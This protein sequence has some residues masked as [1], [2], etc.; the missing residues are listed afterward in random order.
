MNE[1]SSPFFPQCGGLI[2]SGAV[3]AT[4]R[5]DP[6][7]GAVSP[8]RLATNCHYQHQHGQQSNSASANHAEQDQAFESFHSSFSISQGKSEVQ[9]LQFLLF[10]ELQE[11]LGLIA[12]GY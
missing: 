12:P 5:L 7:Q 2:A 6:F 4:D 1:L 3:G 11:S 9:N 8:L 10:S